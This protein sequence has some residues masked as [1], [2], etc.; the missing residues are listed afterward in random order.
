MLKTQKPKPNP[1]RFKVTIDIDSARSELEKVEWSPVVNSVSLDQSVSHFTNTISDTLLKFSKKVT[2]SRSKTILRHWMTIGLIRCSKNCDKLHIDLRK[3]PN[4]PIK[5]LVY[6]RYRNFYVGLIRKLK[7]EYYNKEINNNKSSSKKLWST[8]NLIAGKGNA[9]SSSQPL[10]GSKPSIEES[11]DSCNSYFSSV[12]QSLASSIMVKLN[13]T[14]ESLARKVLIHDQ[15]PSSFFWDPT[16]SQE[17]LDLI[18]S[19]NPSSAPGID[20][21]TNKFLQNI[22]HVIAEPL[23]AIFNLSMSSGVFPSHWKTA[24][25]TPVHKSGDMENPSNYRPGWILQ[26]FGRHCK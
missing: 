9:S 23:A 16:D 1:S 15:P 7:F 13:E 24:A 26:T 10:L 17:I 6:T 19:L 3:D 8:I 11:L 2:T 21:V 4:N 5:K 18:R 14:Q 25:V 22:A 12:G 20:G